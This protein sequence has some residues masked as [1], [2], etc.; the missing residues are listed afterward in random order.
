MIPRPT[1]TQLAAQLG[2]SPSTVSRAFTRPDLLRTDTVDRVLAAAQAVG[3]VP[4]NHA[5]ALSTGKAGAIGLIVPDIANPF[6]PPLIRAAQ[7][8]ATAAG[9]A[10]FLADSDENPDRE[11]RL[12]IAMAPQVEGLL[13]VS[14]RL[15]S[16]RLRDLSGRYRLA[17]VNRDVGG[18]FRVLLDATSAIHAALSHL[19]G[20]G[21]T[22]IAYVGGPERSWSNR[23]RR[24]AVEKRSRELGLHFMSYSA[25]P[26]TYEA[27]K[28]LS[29][30]VVGNGATAVIAF[31]DVL[32]HGL[33]GGF[34]EEKVDVPGDVSIIG[35]DDALAT[36]TFPPLSTISF[37]VDEAAAEA[38]HALTAHSSPGTLPATRVA[39]EGSLVLR[40]TTST[41]RRD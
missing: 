3:Y 32:A 16:S 2:V 15:P 36:T 28:A 38:V 8:H 23:Q 9:L 5:R 7:N 34:A 6:F 19:A 14:S 24:A 13:V 29:R 35:C 18:T 33:M 25:G 41:P 22:R 31:D 10:V 40:G 17:L 21:H 1:I 26:G 37:R 4:N 11:E 12:I 27:A 20:L 30:T 39:F